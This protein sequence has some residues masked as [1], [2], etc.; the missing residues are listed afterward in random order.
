MKRHMRRTGLGAMALMATLGIVLE[1]VAAP[2]I[3]WERV[4]GIYGAY[5]ECLAATDAGVLFAGT[6]HGVYRSVDGESWEASGFQTAR[7]NA[8][9]AVDGDIYVSSE[10]AATE[11]LHRS[12][13]GGST[14]ERVSRRVQ[15]RAFAV[16]NGAVYAAYN[17]G[18][19]ATVGRSDDRGVAWVETD[20]DDARA[21]SAVATDLVVFAAT[22]EGVYASSDDGASWRDI[23]ATLPHND[24]ANDI[25]LADGVLYAAVDAHGVH[26]YDSVAEAWQPTHLQEGDAYDLFTAADALYAVVG[27][28]PY[29]QR[30]RLLRSRDGG[31]DWQQVHVGHGFVTRAVAAHAGRI[32]VGGAG[33]VLASDD[34]GTNWR[35]VSRGMP[36]APLYD[37]VASG[38]LVYAG[39]DYG[40]YA[41]EDRGRTWRRT[42][43]YLH[44][45]VLSADG[46]TVHAA[47]RWGGLFRSDDG[48]RTWREV[49][50]GVPTREGRSGIY[51][52]SD[53]PREILRTNGRVYVAYYHGAFLR[54]ADGE[55]WERVRGSQLDDDR[56]Y[57]R[58]GD[59]PLTIG[60]HDGA[61][62]AN[63]HCYMARSF[64]GGSKWEVLPAGPCLRGADFHS[65]GGRLYIAAETGV[66]RWNET[67]GE[68]LDASDGLPLRREDRPNDDRRVFSGTRLASLGK[69]LYVGSQTHAG[70]YR[71]YEGTDEWVS[72]GLDGAHTWGLLAY[73]DALF[74]GTDEGLF[75]ATVDQSVGVEPR[76]KGATAW[77]RIKFAAL[78]PERS[79]LLPNY[80][81]PFNPETW[82][83]FD[84]AESARVVLRIYDPRGRV[85]RTLDLG[86]LSPGRYRDRDRAAHWDGRDAAGSP[87]ASGVYVVEITAGS[88]SARRKMV[89]R[90]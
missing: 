40:V 41:S 17:R 35:D 55:A 90:K 85:V 42:R 9:L 58:I 51:L 2:G 52:A 48:G 3:V 81:N 13:D 43:L 77:G 89:V 72:A 54:S 26:R 88:Y 71:L 28:P 30:R 65:F 31:V 46:R 10:D 79:A 67:A 74:A 6:G 11:G 24:G 70:V 39:S 27:D 18:R 16:K 33:G 21:I 38:D 59:G 14:W 29:A 5:V 84:L 86:R 47:T 69:S 49:N 62:Y 78:T 20:L 66:Y 61:L 36:H 87:A 44:A 1:A 23:D 80:P 12:S 53:N 19:R 76:G 50:D 8:V 37:I 82:I 63:A 83:P 32:Y 25:T 4:D 75:R 73:D 57:F 34:G 45:P 15:P 68:W 64:D 7:I 56:S 22:T 60:E